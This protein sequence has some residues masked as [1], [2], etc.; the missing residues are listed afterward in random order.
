M[1]A[2]Q[3]VYPVDSGQWLQSCLVQSLRTPEPAR[4]WQP[5][6]EEVAHPG[7]FADLAE[8]HPGVLQVGQVLLAWGKIP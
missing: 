4:A 8:V 5:R 7:I 6:R 1:I 2:K 3:R